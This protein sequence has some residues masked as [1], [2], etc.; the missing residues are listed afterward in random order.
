MY[1][2]LVSCCGLLK[3]MLI[4]KCYFILLLCLRMTT[5]FKNEGNRIIEYDN[6][7]E[8]KVNDPQKINIYIFEECSNNEFCNKVKENICISR[9]IFEMLM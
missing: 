7:E 6:F 5:Q 8:Y 3:N 9:T 4:Y 2:K 1:L